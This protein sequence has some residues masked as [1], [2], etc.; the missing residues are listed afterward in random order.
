M[1]LNDQLN[2]NNGEG[3]DNEL[4]FLNLKNAI[5]RNKRQIF[6]FTLAGI[7]LGFL[8]GLQK[9]TWKGEFEIVLENKNSGIASRFGSIISGNNSQILGNLVG[10]KSGSNSIKTEIEIL[11]S[12]SVL[13]DIFEFV[14]NQKIKNKNSNSSI[15]FMDWRENLN[16]E[17]RQDTSVLSISYISPEK[18]S[19]IP[20]LNRISKKYQQYS[21]KKRLKQIN[22][23]LNFFD[24]QIKTYTEKSIQSVKK[25]QEFSL[26]YDFG[27]SP[28]FTSNKYMVGDEQSQNPET[29]RVAALNELRIIN[30]QLDKIKQNKFNPDEIFYFSQSYLKNSN[31]PENISRLNQL[32]VELAQKRTVFKENDISIKRL[33]KSEK[34][35][36]NEVKKQVFGALKARKIELESILDASQRPDG[37]LIKYFQLIS[38]A[39]E[40]LNT[41]ENLKIQSRVLS[42]EKE[43]SKEP[44]QLITNPTLLPNPIAPK[45]KRIVAAG[46]FLGF[47]SG[48]GFARIKE[49]RKNLILN[50]NHIIQLSKWDFLCELKINSWESSLETLK[51]LALGRLSNSKKN[52]SIIKVGNFESQILDRLIK[53]LNSFLPDKEIKIFT[54]ITDANEFGEI[55]PIALINSSSVTDLENMKQNL[56]LQ[57]SY[58]EEVKF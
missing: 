33:I 43:K 45:R 17:L 47:V 40:D 22:S 6:Y 48:C 4:E 44:W 19:I 53:V 51:C 52:I 30:D 18:E 2:L 26:K 7:F 15:R 1:T 29:V 41:L 16:F 23:G 38:E 8:F 36:N 9:N 46:I 11:K 56:S 21:G 54:D 35:S 55:I 28:I 20:V 57:N 27:I 50:N 31:I 37:I 58:L 25:A 39:K 10:N 14:K 13:M 32:K 49:G 5:F 3:T 12:P 42:L 34:A 24:E